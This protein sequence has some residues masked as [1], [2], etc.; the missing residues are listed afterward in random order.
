MILFRKQTDQE[1]GRLISQSNHFVGF[2]IP[3]SFTESERETMR[4]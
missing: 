4:N 1:D 3:V 2:W